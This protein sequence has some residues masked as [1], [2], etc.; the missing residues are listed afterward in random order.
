MK[1]LIRKK[2][3]P[4]LKKNV[5]FHFGGVPKAKKKQIAVFSLWESFFSFWR[6]QTEKKNHSKVN[7]NQIWKEGRRTAIVPRAV[8]ASAPAQ[9]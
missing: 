9:K 8:A 5:F 7:K 3:F 2:R 4:K 1:D 6:F